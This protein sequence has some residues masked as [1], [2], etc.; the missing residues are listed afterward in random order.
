MSRK[1]VL[2]L[3]GGESSEH[4]IS[5]WSAV[6]VLDSIDRES[7]EVLTA[8]IT[9]K[10]S[11]YLTGAPL[12][13]IGDGS[14]EQDKGNAP[15]ALS[16]DRENPGFLCVTEE[17]EKALAVD[18]VFPVLHGLYGE[19][20]TVQGM[21]RMAGIPCVGSDTKTSAACMDKGLAKALVEQAEAAHQ[22]KCCILYRQNCDPEEAAEGVEEF[23]RGKYP[24][25]VK[26]SASGSSV[27]ISKVRT[28]Q[29]LVD[30]IGVAFAEDDKIL[31]EEA[32]EGRELEVA[33]LGNESP[34]ASPVGE[35]FSAHEFYDYEAKYQDQGSRTALAED[36]P[37][38]ILEEIRE[39]AVLVYR[40]LE[41]R[42]LARVDFFLREDGTV[43]FNEINTMPGFTDISMY[44]QLWMAAG[45]SYAQLIDRLITL[46]LEG[47]GC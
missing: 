17:G 18:V 24:L 8:G 34:E 3:F 1:K 19:D 23:F 10:G 46:A 14:W 45:M 37:E 12:P 4:D 29:E 6:C 28:R 26:P 41:C 13:A 43:I 40:I 39:T 7:Y 15:L 35:I 21:L 11:W 32:I 16:L 33:V 38:E 30:G 2:V 5:R 9:R 44:P 36:I 31:I 42:G 27:G 47:E 22:A 25:F 20:G